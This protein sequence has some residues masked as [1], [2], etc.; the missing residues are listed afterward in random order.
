MTRFEQL[1]LAKWNRIFLWLLAAHVPVAAAISLVYGTSIRTSLLVGTLILAGPAGLYFSGSRGRLTAHAMAVA[2]MSFSTLLIHASGGCSEFH[3]HIFVVMTLVAIF[4]NPWVV[5]TAGATIAVQHVA[6]YAYLPRS[7]F[8]YPASWAV[9]VLH[10][11]FVVF[12]AVPA[13]WFAATFGRLVFAGSEAISQ[14]VDVLEAV[15]NGD[16]TG[17][18][19]GPRRWS[20]PTA[21]G[22]R[23]WRRRQRPS[24]SS[25]RR[26]RCGRRSTR[27]SR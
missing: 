4:G 3:F 6:V 8:N 17:Q 11:A 24:A 1:H 15:G 9:V 2:L 20:R 19:P 22:P 27:S 14:V 5:L 12:A 7:L 13:M 25:S 23:P 26:R 21:S 18:W 16:L 10:A